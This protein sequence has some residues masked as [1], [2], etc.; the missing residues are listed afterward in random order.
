MLFV[1]CRTEYGDELCVSVCSLN[2]D[3]L[4][5]NILYLFLTPLFYLFVSQPCSPPPFTVC[6]PP[7]PSHL[8]VW[9]RIF[10]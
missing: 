3:F 2:C 10:S 6:P 4:C 7:P 9:H 1:A 5:H 8:I